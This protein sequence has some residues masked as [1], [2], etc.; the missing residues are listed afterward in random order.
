MRLE[1][2]QIQN[3]LLTGECPRELCGLTALKFFDIS[4]NDL[5][6]TV[7]EDVG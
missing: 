6:G 4:R 5:S 1:K 2:L 3:N 7:P